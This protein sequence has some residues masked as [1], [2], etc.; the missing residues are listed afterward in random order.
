MNPSTKPLRWTTQRV[1][2]ISNPNRIQKQKPSKTRKITTNQ[3]ANE[4]PVTIKCPQ[5]EIE[6]LQN[7]LE[8]TYDAV[9]TITVN[10]QSLL[11][12][13]KCSEPQLEKTKSAT[14]LCE[15]EKE[16]LTAYD[17]LTLQV[18][19]LERKIAKLEKRITTLKK[20]EESCIPTYIS[21]PC[22]SVESSISD[23]TPCLDPIQLN[24][25]NNDFCD[26]LSLPDNQLYY[27]YQYYPPCVYYPIL[28]DTYLYHSL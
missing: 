10:F 6:R 13:Y 21:S 23:V 25:V 11:H 16:L 5:K 15:M 27:D 1:H 2:K 26:L 7:E 8:F 9:A 22:S 20:I 18:S 28:E 3:A 4:E 24:F 17:D 19:H 12:A 14:R